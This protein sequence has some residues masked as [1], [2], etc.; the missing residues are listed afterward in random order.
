MKINKQN[1]MKLWR[2]RYGDDNDVCDYAGR[3]MFFLDYNNRES[4]YG[5][6]IDHILPQDRNGADDAENLII[7][8][9]KTN[10]EKA[11]KTTFEANNKK[12]QVKKIDGN[13]E[14][15]N[16]FSNPEIYEDPKL[17]YDFYN[18]EEEIDFAN[19]EIHFDD[20]QNEKSKYGWDICLINT[21]VGPIEGNLTIANIETIKEKNNKNSFTANGYKFQIHKDDNGNYTLFSPDIIADKFDIDAILKFI[22]AKEKK[23]FMAYSIIDLSN[24]KKYR[25]DD[26][27]FILMKTAK[28][29][30]GLVIDM[31][32][33]I[34]TEI[35]EKNI[36]VYF[37]CEYQHDTRK[38]IEFNILL[39][40]Y[41]IMFENKHKIS[42]DIAS[43]LIEVPE[44]Y[45]FMTLDKLIE[46]SN[47]IE[48][49]V[50]CLN[51]QRYS[52]MYIGE[53]MK[54]NLDI[55]QYKM[56]DYKNFYDKLGINYQVYECDYT[57]N[58]LYEEVK[59]IC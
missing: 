6:N 20:F 41:K 16:H 5:W 14:I 44:N 50:K 19:R 57:L 18:E 26:F 1:A 35:N 3:P 37:D 30:Q 11:N 23:I 31:K 32:N 56:S 47:S 12:F 55:K 21:Q 33:F 13:Y 58:G 38:V 40:T 52:T 28:L 45:K 22:N 48:C 42:I 2:S 36:V 27:D 8:N 51:T 49:L 29:I 43:D 46:C 25:S 7:C 10:D 39:N 53:C 59:K 17:W 15:C 24:A 4:K 54:E 34:R 9:I